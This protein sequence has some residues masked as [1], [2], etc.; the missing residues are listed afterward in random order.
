MLRNGKDYES[1][2]EELIELRIEDAKEYQMH[3]KDLLMMTTVRSCE[4]LFSP[5]AKPGT[6]DEISDCEV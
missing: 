3:V 4:K 1:L 6:E 5:I 2:L